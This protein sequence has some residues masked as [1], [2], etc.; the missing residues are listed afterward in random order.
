MNAHSAPT[1]ATDGYATPVAVSFLVTSYN[2]ADYLPA[3]LE[4]VWDEA[5][6]VGGEIVLVDDGSTDGSERICATFAEAHPT[7]HY[8]RQDNCGIYATMN[9]IASKARGD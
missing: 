5:R 8:W 9:I 1:G 6:S 7:V 2:K 3:V 4:S